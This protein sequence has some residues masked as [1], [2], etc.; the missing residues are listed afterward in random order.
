MFGDGTTSTLQNPPP[1]YYP[2]PPTREGRTYPASF[3]VQND[4]GCFDT[5]RLDIKVYYNCHVAVP[6]A[7]TPNGDGLNDFLYPA[8]AYKA[9]DLIFRVYNRWGQLVFET[10]SIEPGWNGKFKDKELPEDIYI[11]SIYA[12]GTN[13]HPFN[14]RGI[15]V[16]LR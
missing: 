1:K 2:P 11:Y 7:F 10:D 8:D 6:S 14:K 13:N 9:D 5:A 12:H 16:L 4:I 3:I 15:I